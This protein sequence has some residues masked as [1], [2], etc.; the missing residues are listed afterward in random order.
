MRPSCTMGE[1]GEK[2]F[3]VKARMYPEGKIFVK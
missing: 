1:R 2:V 3:L